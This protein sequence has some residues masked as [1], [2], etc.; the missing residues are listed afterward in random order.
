[1][2]FINWGVCGVKVEDIE[3]P[4]M[5]EILYLDKLIDELAKWKAADK[6][7]KVYTFP[8]NMSGFS[9]LPCRVIAEV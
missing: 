2:W 7:F 4:I 5:N 9:G 8:V 6:P 3:E 1:M